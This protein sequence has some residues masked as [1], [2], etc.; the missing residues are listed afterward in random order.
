MTRFLPAIALL[1]GFTALPL[2]EADAQFYFGSQRFG[3][4]ASHRNRQ[5]DSNF[6]RVES[7]FVH[8]PNVVKLD[9]YADRLAKIAEHLHDDAHDLSQDYHHS[10]SIERYVD[11]LEQLQ[12]HMHSIL[13]HAAGDHHVDSGMLRHIQTDVTSAKSLLGRLDRELRHQSH[14]GTRRHDSQLILHMRR[15]IVREAYPLLGLMQNE[16]TGD[17]YGSSTGHHHHHP[18]W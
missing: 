9:E 11:Q 3:S 2:P 10:D 8:R 4:H 12:K 6:H 18:G 14:D 15:I 5:H 16:L 1:F 17:R 7:R 13:H